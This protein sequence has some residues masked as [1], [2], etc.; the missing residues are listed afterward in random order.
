[1]KISTRFAAS[2]FATLASSSAFA[3]QTWRVLDPEN[4]LLI[5]SSK[6]RLILE[7]R[8]DMAPKSVERV[9]LLTREKDYEQ[10]KTF[11]GML[12]SDF[13]GAPLKSGD[14]G[15]FDCHCA[16]VSENAGF[17][18]VP[19]DQMQYMEL[20]FDQTSQVLPIAVL[21]VKPL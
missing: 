15:R 14:S 9:K 18:A 7:M 20:V 11:N 6:G 3:Q 8:P 21:W 17:Q 16:L 2:L 10:K 1:M 12:V 4:T 13:F 5:E 19:R